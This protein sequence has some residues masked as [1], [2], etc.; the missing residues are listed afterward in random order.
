M[1]RQTRIQR[2]LITIKDDI[3][4]KGHQMKQKILEEAEGYAQNGGRY[5]QN[6]LDNYLEFADNKF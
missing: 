6:M 4:V 2:F 3:K 5:D 1:G